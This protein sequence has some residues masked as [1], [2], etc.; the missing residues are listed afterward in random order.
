MQPSESGIVSQ[1]ADIGTDK[2]EPNRSYSHAREKREKNN[3][4]GTR[5]KLYPFFQIRK[6]S[7][8]GLLTYAGNPF[9]IEG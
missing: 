8:S 1:Q 4:T 2:L 7:F 3:E 6:E 5:Q 9:I